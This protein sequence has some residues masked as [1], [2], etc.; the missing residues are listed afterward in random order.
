[1]FITMSDGV[2]LFAERKGQGTPCLFLHG[3]PGYW[4]KSF[5]HIAGPLLESH[6]DMIY[7]DQRGCGR[8]SHD[9]KD[10][11]LKRLIS[12]IEEVR[13]ALQIKSLFLMG[14]SFGGIL[15]VQYAHRFG[16]HIEGIILMNAALNLKVLLNQQINKGEELLHIPH[17]GFLEEPRRLVDRFFSTHRK[18]YEADLYDGLQFVYPH[19]K[20][21]LDIVDKDLSMKPYFQQA[22]F[23]SPEY[24]ADFS[25]L[26]ADI[27]NPT[28]ILAG[29]QD[30]AVGPHHHESFQFPY[31]EIEVLNGAHHPFIENRE[32]FREAITS[33]IAKHRPL[34][35]HREKAPL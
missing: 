30:Y 26:T 10:F 28:L 21:Q 13:Q 25:L 3:G 15:A 31:Q 32:E 29:K 18:L 8:S 17:T 34:S 16:G 27:T 6:L 2:E 22:V 20:A 9:T 1:M 19:N 35:T 12:D 23:S 4:S 7:L 14:H 33:F 11:T 24:F 5:S